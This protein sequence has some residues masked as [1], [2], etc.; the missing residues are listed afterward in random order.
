MPFEHI[1]STVAPFAMEHDNRH[2][3]R[4]APHS[5][6]AIAL[7]LQIP[8]RGIAGFIYP[9]INADGTAGASI[10]LFGPGLPEA[11]EERFEAAPVPAEMD[12]YDWQVQ[13][14]SYRID[15]PHRS[16][17]YRFAGRRVKIACRFE[18]FHPVYPFSAHPEGCPQYYADDRTEQHGW[19]TGTMEIDGNRFEFRSLGQRDHAWGARIWGVNQHYKWF[20][21]TTEA[22]AIHFFEMQS[23]GTR[24]I[25]GFVFKDEAMAQVTGVECKYF[26]D[27]GMHHR[28]VAARLTDDLGRTTEVRAEVYAK[29]RFEADPKVVLNEGGITVTIEGRKG[30]GW[31]E[32]CWN[33]DYFEFARNH[34]AA[35]PPFKDLCFAD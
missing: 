7:M 12:F 4:D 25:R 11:I 18:A 9:W 35:Y 24:H 1:R 23:F 29:F 20:H 3:L 17:D 28:A 22:A 5:R 10:S 27:E 33:R 34:V 2:A 6:E 16:A 14:L 8:E 26:F 30:T 15:E 32:F 13:G 19:I 21:A 31:C